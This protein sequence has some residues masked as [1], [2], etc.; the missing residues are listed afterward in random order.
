MRAPVQSSEHNASVVVP[1]VSEQV[2]SYSISEGAKFISIVIPFPFSK[3][4]ASMLA[5]ENRPQRIH[6]QLGMS[7]DLLGTRFLLTGI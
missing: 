3:R 6:H 1:R 2:N 5:G 4:E 7:L